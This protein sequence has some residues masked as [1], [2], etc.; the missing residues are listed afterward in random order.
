MN[1]GYANHI[2]KDMPNIRRA[3]PKQNEHEVFS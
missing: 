2:K 1:L 3:I